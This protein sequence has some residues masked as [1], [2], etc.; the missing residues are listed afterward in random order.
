MAVCILN[1]MARPGRKMLQDCGN[2]QVYGQIDGERP[3]R[4]KRGV[5][6]HVQGILLEDG[7]LEM[8]DTKTKLGRMA[9]Y[10]HFLPQHFYL[11]RLSQEYP[12]A[13][14]VLSL[15]NSTQWAHSVFNWFQMRGRV[16]N[17][18]IYFNKTIER[19]GKHRAIEFL[20][21]I[22]DEHT[23]FVRQFVQDHP[24]HTLVEIN[25]TDPNAGNILGDAFGLDPQCWGHHNKLG[26][27]AKNKK[28][29]RFDERHGNTT[30]TG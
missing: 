20:V 3:I 24:S 17:E 1:N 26:N 14:L 7:S 10:R 9:M 11:E 16:V 8:H 15:R 4:R 29:A 23:A 13:T 27:R 28:K 19:P 6:Q 30:I 21:R 25:I 18:Y 5:P 12:Q 2:Y 22:Y